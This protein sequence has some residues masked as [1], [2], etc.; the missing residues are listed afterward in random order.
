MTMDDDDEFNELKQQHYLTI[1]DTNRAVAEAFSEWQEKKKAAAD[2]KKLLDGLSEDLTN[3]I[4]SG[5]EEPGPQRELP[6]DEDADED[7]D[8]DE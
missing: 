3:L 7:H 8:D 4:S 6:F 2:A 1:I 5:P